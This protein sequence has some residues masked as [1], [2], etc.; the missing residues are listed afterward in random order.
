MHRLAIE[1]MPAVPHFVFGIFNLG[2][3][4]IIFWVAV[5]IVFI[6]GSRARMPKF[7]EHSRVVE[8]TDQGGDH[9]H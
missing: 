3:P 1:T 7:M 8:P 4:N 2:V 5:I 6:V 9:E